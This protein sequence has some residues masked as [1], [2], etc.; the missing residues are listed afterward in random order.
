MEKFMKAFGR[1]SFKDKMIL[2]ITF[3]VLLVGGFILYLRS[4]FGLTGKVAF[5]ES[6]LSGNG[7]I[8]TNRYVEYSDLPYTIQY[9]GTDK[10]ISVG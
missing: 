1:L 2:Y 4:M 5:P 6:S 9:P 10:A 3:S 7:S 8:Q